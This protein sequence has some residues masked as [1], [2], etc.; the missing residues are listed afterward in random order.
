[1]GALN[2][3]LTMQTWRRLSQDFEQLQNWDL[4]GELTARLQPKLSK[5]I[6]REHIQRT[7]YAM[8]IGHPMVD[9]YLVSETGE[10]LFALKPQ[11]EY[12]SKPIE[13]TPLHI[14]SADRIPELPVLGDDPASHE[15]TIFSVSK[16]II[17][18]QAGYVYLVLSN[19]LARAMTRQEGQYYVLGYA[20]L[21]TGLITLFASLLGLLLFSLL[22]KN[23]RRLLHIVRKYTAGEL[24]ARIPVDGNDEIAELSIAINQMAEQIEQSLEK[25]EATDLSRRELIANV[26]H[27]LRGPLMVMEGY[28]ELLASNWSELEDSKREEYLSTISRNIVSQ[29]KLISDLFELSKLEAREKTPDREPF[30]LLELCHDIV[31]ERQTQALK[32]QQTLSVQ[33][34]NTLPDVFADVALIS[35]V[36]TNLVDNACKY[37]GS[38]SSIEVRITE[39]NGSLVVAVVDDGVGIEP[40]DLPRIFDSFY[41]ADKSRTNSSDGSGL[42]LAIVR[43]SIEAHGG[44]ISV[45]S[46]PGQGCQFTFTLPLF[47]ETQ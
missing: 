20:A 28:A 41:R 43:S 42:G 22:S 29:K 46:S 35:R 31:Q 4:A 9:F 17:E 24:S 5:A 11:S 38:G 27:D 8:A 12:S 23:F 19:P 33:A 37:S 39:K 34:A 36:V 3:V 15:K 25:L 13:V 45:V 14:A 21:L 30:S 26:S 1:M 18:G 6:D 40:E 44:T 2:I 47:Q 10:I 16:T 7:M 32:Q